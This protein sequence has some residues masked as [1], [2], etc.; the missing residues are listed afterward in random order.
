MTPRDALTLRA[1]EGYLE[2]GMLHE[3]GA[4]LDGLRG[5]V[6]TRIAA[7]MMRSDIASRLRNWPLMLQC[8]QEWLSLQPGNAGALI[9]LAFATRRTESIPAAREILR[10]AEQQHPDD[11]LIRYN[12]AC[13]ACQAGDIEEAQTRLR[14][15]FAADASYVTLATRDDDLAPL[16]DWITTRRRT[17]SREPGTT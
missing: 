3:A 14:S 10:G 12:L 8:S 16:R 2:L 17:E 15:V 4:E 7:L 5:D 9:S 6:D 13:Y 11:V 1:A